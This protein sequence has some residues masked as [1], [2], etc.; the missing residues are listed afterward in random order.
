[1]DEVFDQFLVEVTPTRAKATQRDDRSGTKLLRTFFGKMA[2]GSIQPFHI[3]EYLSE[4]AKKARVRANREKALLSAVFNFMIRKGLVSANPCLGV[5][6]LPEYP[7]ER[8]PERWEIQELLSVA[9]E[10]LRVYVPFKILTGFRQGQILA[11]R[12]D[13]LKDDGIHYVQTKRGKR[14]IMIWTP[15]LRAA[16]DAIGKL[17]RPVASMYLFCNRK[18]QPYSPDGF[19][20]IGH[21]AMAKALQSTRLSERFTE[22]DLR[23]AT[24]TAAF[25]MGLDP[26]ELLG[27]TNSKTTEVYL[28]GKKPM[29]VSPLR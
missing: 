29:K 4:R 19:R 21:R 12:K 22:H 7:R 15:D 17:P 3:Y 25:E 24:G 13:Q 6:S 9:P 18:G 28:R 5:E 20:S 8:L 27:H 11:L 14:R 1:M 23:A 10:L 16:I 2:P 26:Q